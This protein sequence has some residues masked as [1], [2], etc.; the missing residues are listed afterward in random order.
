MEGKIRI[1]DKVRKF[2][3]FIMGVVEMRR[4]EENNYQRKRREFM[5]AEERLESLD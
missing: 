4:H 3:V 2:I 5:W 1:K